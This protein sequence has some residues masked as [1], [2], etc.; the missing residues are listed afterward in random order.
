MDD[1]INWDRGLSE[2]ELTARI[3]KPLFIKKGFG[4]DGDVIMSRVYKECSD[5]ISIKEAVKLC[6]ETIQTTKIENNMVM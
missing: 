3:L 6:R 1:S 2:K 4:G 5:L